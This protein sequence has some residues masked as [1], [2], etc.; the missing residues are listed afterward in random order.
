MYADLRMKWQPP[1]VAAAAAA[2][3]AAADA[4]ADAAMPASSAL[5]AT[6][7]W[8]RHVLAFIFTC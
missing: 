8:L 7:T 5:A 3:D 2:A 6:L 4:D 1:A